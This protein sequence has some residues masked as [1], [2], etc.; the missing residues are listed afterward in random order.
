M[1]AILAAFPLVSSAPRIP[2]LLSPDTSI[3]MFPLRYFDWAVDLPRL[4]WLVS[5][6]CFRNPKCFTCWFRSK[7][8][9]FHR[10]L[11]ENTIT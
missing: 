11:L 1:I 5:H 2:R 8:A 6:W 7:S 10:E 9:V 3:S 4:K